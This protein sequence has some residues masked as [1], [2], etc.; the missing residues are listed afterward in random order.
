[1]SIPSHP[2]AGQVALVTGVSSGIGRETARLLIDRGALVHG[3]SRTADSVPEGVQHIPCDL[4]DPADLEASISSLDHLDMLV[5]NAGVAYRSKIIDGDLQ[6]WQQM[7]DL[8]VRAPALLCQHCLPLMGKGA[9]V[10]NISSQS[11]HRVPPSGGFYAATKFALRGITDALRA[12]LA[13][14]PRNI[15]V[16]TISPGFVDTALLDTYFAGREEELE[17]TKETVPMLTAED[18]AATIIHMLC[19]PPHVAFDDIRIRSA[20]QIG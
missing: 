2:L 18:V 14:D 17:K 11:G 19:A 3:I 10:L 13:D 6:H 8:N 4:T 5:N 9:R 12:E 16:A 1:M 7:L 15:R 20:G